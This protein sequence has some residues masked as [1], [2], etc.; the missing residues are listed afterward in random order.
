V[1]PPINPAGPGWRW[2]SPVLLLSIPTELLTAGRAGLWLL[3]LVFVAPLLAL[4]LSP[5][6][7]PPARNRLAGT[8]EAA[9]RL[10]MVGAILWANLTLAGDVAFWMGGS[11]W[12]GVLVAGGGAVLLAALGEDE[13]RRRLLGV[14]ALLGLAVPLL[15]VALATDP[16]P[17]RVWSRVASQAAFRFPPDS[18]WVSE[19]RSVSGRRGA[20]TLLFEEEHRLTPLTEGR[21]RVST[22]D[23]RS[24]RDEE[25]AVTPGRPVTVRP[26]DRLHLDGG[27]RFRFEAEKRIPGAPVSGIAWAD[28]P[29]RPRWPALLRVLG[30]G[31]TLVGGAAALSV[32]GGARSRSGTALLGLFLLAVVVWSECWALYGAAYAPELFLGGVTPEKLPELPALVLRGE[33]SGHWLT[34]VALAGLLA[35]LL[36]TAAAL[37]QAL[38][39]TEPAASARARG[40]AMMEAGVAPARGPAMMEAGV[41][42]ARAPAMITEE[43]AR[44]W[45]LWGGLVALAGV[46]SLWSHD[47]WML[48]SLALG[49]GA[50][51]LAPLAVMGGRPRASAGALAVGSTLFVGLA[52]LGRLAS[53]QANV[54]LSFPALIAAPAAWGI[55]WLARRLSPE[56]E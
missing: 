15:V 8:L 36:A 38:T 34:W 6:P 24:V 55:L 39:R 7:A 42:P 23:G 13:R 45:R 44:D 32:P 47:A 10:L 18:P 12:S 5:F 20:E 48:L 41:A 11:R 22:S 30:V 25:L 49:L 54:V 16:V 14:L 33:P 26:G 28:A 27:T 29:S 35:G 9:L 1:S 51:T 31:V 4:L 56:A 40:P 21:M 19:G 52:A 46:A 2:L 3:L 43:I 37:R 50:S 17:P 53:A